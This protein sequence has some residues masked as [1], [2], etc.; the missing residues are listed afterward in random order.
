MKTIHLHIKNMV[1]PRC[2]LVVQ[3]ELKTLGA[4]ILTLRLGYASV[5]LPDDVTKKQ[6][7]SGLHKYGF[8]LL[9]DKDNILLEQIKLSIQEYIQTLEISVKEIMLSEYLA[10]ELGKNYNLLSKLFSKQEGETIETYYINKRIERVKE[11]LQYEEL[12]LSEIAMKL[13][14]SSVHYLSSQFKRVTGL[15]VSE[16]KEN[17]KE[18]QHLYKNLSEALEA[19]RAKGYTYSFNKKNDCLE[20]Q[21][22]CVSYKLDEL[23]I[24]EFYRFQENQDT[25]GNS[26]VYGVETQ[27][28]LKGLFIDSRHGQYKKLD[29]P[30]HDKLDGEKAGESS[31]SDESKDHT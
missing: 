9:E 4:D 22:L 27:D 24:S 6:I 23:Q 11:L 28:G 5:R 13:G 14:Y 10:R 3:N 26:V 16:F 31:P 15:S 19:L 29:H 30:L 1:C 8:E 12:N 21:D 2:I 18:E 25:A 17:L 20:C 7:S